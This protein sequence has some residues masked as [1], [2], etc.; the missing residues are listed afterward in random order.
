M[1]ESR[2]KSAQ[3]VRRKNEIEEELRIV[4]GNISSQKTKLRE[5]NVLHPY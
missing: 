2:L 5:L 1:E 4:E 3:A